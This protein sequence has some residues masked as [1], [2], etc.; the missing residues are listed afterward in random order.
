MSIINKLGIA[1]FLWLALA[2]S[3]ALAQ[4]IGG[5]IS[6]IGSGGGGGSGCVPSGA[7][8]NILTDSGSGSCN[9]D[10]H[11]NVSN[12]A[13]SLGASGTA[14][15]VAFGNATSGVIT[16]QPVTGALGT[17]TLLLPAANGTLLY[18][19]GPLGT[20]SSGTVTN[21]TGTASININGT[22]GA[23]T[24]TTGV[25]T[26]VD[27]TSSITIGA[28]SAI[29][30]SGA[31]GALGTN[32]F[33]STAYA[34]LAS[35]TF[36]GTVTLPDGTTWT[37]TTITA[38]IGAFIFP[39]DSVQFIGTGSG[40]TQIGTHQTSNTNRTLSIPALTGNDDFTTNAAT[41]TLTNKTI[42][43]A[44]N[45][46]TGV[47]PLA[48]PTFTGTVTLPD[49]TAC[50]SSGCGS[51]TFL[52]IGQSVPSTYVLGVTG[53]TQTSASANGIVSM[54][55]T[56]N[57]SGAP[58]AFSLAVTNTASGSS[59]LLMNLLAGTSGTTSEFKVASNG[60][61]TAANFYSGPGYSATT[62]SGSN[63]FAHN[64]SFNGIMQSVLANGNTGT[65]AAYALYFGSSTSNTESSIIQGGSGYTGG[66]GA[67]SFTIS[68][69]AGI[70]LSYGSSIGLQITSG[71]G[72]TAPNLPSSD[73][74]NFLCES[75]G[76]IGQNGTSCVGSRLDWKYN[77][78]AFDPAGQQSLL[79]LAQRS[80]IDVGHL[81]SVPVSAL[82]A[83][84]LT[85]QIVPT[86]FRGDGIHV[87]DTSLQFGLIAQN[88]CEVDERLCSR[89]KK[90]G[91]VFTW[92]P[93]GMIAL[94]VADVQQLQAQITELKSDI[95][96]LRTTTEHASLR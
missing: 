74:G 51:L 44:S 46:L 42:A 95:A 67:N 19:G 26:T 88:A 9:S 93:N 91:K 54:A 5:G 41:Q 20:P 21:L 34:P 7:S 84:A 82:D 73:A 60:A 61:V 92:R 14:G 57:T 75:S 39:G 94:L 83:L 64:E 33:T 2:A 80:G 8:G 96:A 37:S 58:T 68:G 70:W 78:A 27:A 29:T 18:G 63:G 62:A 32:A 13:L 90:T 50:T 12:G 48:S 77:V 16:L 30:S 15:S 86:E 69:G 24:A 38:G 1:I 65:G 45:T 40:Y 36:T 56:W 79:S 6:N 66:N 35:P 10:S 53:T 72:L 47:A 3:A 87:T 17:D 81:A 76:V 89:D 52:G 22:V 23:T 85:D 59:S 43:I 49:S 4:N 28:G 25:F 31:G 71:G 55:Q 11:T